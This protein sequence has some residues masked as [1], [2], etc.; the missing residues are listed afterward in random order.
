MRFCSVTVGTPNCIR[1]RDGLRH[2]LIFHRFRITIHLLTQEQPRKFG[3]VRGVGAGARAAVRNPS[4]DGGFMDDWD[5]YLN[6]FIQR[7]FAGH[8]RLILLATSPDVVI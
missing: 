1:T 3:K 8:R 4:S 6:A 2:T 5:A 7:R